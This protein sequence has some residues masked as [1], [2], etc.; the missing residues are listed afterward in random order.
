MNAARPFVPD[1]ANIGTT[2]SMIAGAGDGLPQDPALARLVAALF[3]GLTL[4]WLADPEGT[5]R[6]RCSHCWPSCSS[7]TAADP[8]R[9]PDG[10]ASAL[11]RRT[12]DRSNRRDHPACI[13]DGSTDYSP[14]AESA[15]RVGGCS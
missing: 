15:G 8:A 3:D 12:L 7:T 4:S 13:H 5:D 2:F 14:L 1:F 11:H 10:F 9:S 6:T